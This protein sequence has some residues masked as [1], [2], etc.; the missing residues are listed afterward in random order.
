MHALI[1]LELDFLHARR[2]QA[3]GKGRENRRTSAREEKGEI[4]TRKGVD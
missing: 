4:H 1:E 2:E 3:L